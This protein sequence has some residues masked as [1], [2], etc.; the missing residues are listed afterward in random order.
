MNDR[1]RGALIGLAVGDALA[2]PSSSAA[3]PASHPSP[4]TGRRAA[5]PERRGVTRRHLAWRCPGRQ[6]RLGRL[7][8]ER[9]GRALRPVDDAREVSVNGR[10]FD[11]ASRPAGRCTRSW[12]QGRHPFGEAGRRRPAAMGRSCAWPGAG[13]TRRPVPGHV[14]RPWDVYQSSGVRG[15]VFDRAFHKLLMREAARTPAC[16]SGERGCGASPR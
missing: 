13:R 16:A 11:V 5:P 4:A 14:K 10:C 1:R 6:Y 3:P 15:G 9:P 2:P 12:R 7:G 8:L